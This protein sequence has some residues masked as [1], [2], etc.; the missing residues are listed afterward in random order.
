MSMLKP[1]LG[2]VFDEG[3]SSYT[4]S[5]DVLVRCNSIPRHT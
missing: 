2:S 4:V 1:V 5:V 3:K